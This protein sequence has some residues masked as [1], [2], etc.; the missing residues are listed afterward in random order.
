MYLTNNERNNICKRF[1]KFELSYE[2]QIHKK[3]YNNDDIFFAVP[4]GTKYFAWFS[5]YHN[6]NVCFIC[7]LYPNK[8]IKSIKMVT[9]C[10]D[11]ILSHGTILY[12]SIV[13]EKFFVIENIYY[14][15]GKE[16]LCNFKNKINIFHE[17]FEKYIKQ[18][19]FIKNDLV[20]TMPIMSLKYDDVTTIADS[21]PYKIYG[22]KM[23]NLYNNAPERTFVYKLDKKEYFANF[24]IK[25]TIKNDI[26]ETYYYDR[27][28]YKKHNVA[29]IPSYVCSVMM[30]KLF[31][32]IKENG[33]LDSLEES[34]DEDE[35]ENISD[36][37]YVDLNKSFI[38][39]CKFSQKFNK[40]VPLE[41]VNNNEKLITY[42]DLWT[43]ENK[44]IKS[45]RRT[46]F[47]RGRRY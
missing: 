34:D 10:Y 47:P 45:N 28:E 9:T 32:I 5:Y 7:E 43:I 14:Y 3:V 8:K 2:K 11:K 35:F 22:I 17:L 20:F 37:K 41:V 36:D 33:R 23:I 39:K 27:G 40:W 29:Y 25:A 44:F 16:V 4:F 38:M 21:L 18:V 31:R 6:K 46:H 15:C 1:P 26:Y 42:N 19:S 30:N 12:G 13:E 24:K